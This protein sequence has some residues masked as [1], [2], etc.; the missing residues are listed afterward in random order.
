MIADNFLKNPVSR[1][2]LIPLAARAQE[3]LS[4]KALFIDK[5]AEEIF[6]KLPKDAIDFKLNPVMRTATAIRVRYLDD[7]A[8][9][10]IADHKNPI[11]VQLGAGFDT[12][13]SRT[14]NGQSIQINID[15]PEVMQ[16][17]QDFI[18]TKNDREY[19]WAYNITDTAWIERLKKEFRDFDIMFI[20]EG[21]LM[22]LPDND[23]ETL[24]K[25]LAD[26]FIDS[27]IAFDTASL[28]SKKMIN[29]SIVGKMGAC[30]QWSYNYDNSIEQWHP[31]L[32][33]V[34]EKFYFD[35]YRQ[36]LGFFNILRYLP[37]INHSSAIYLYNIHSKSNI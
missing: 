32:K 5:Q 35:L 22:Y 1:T 12:R 31:F 19:N 29:K 24:F 25:S 18:P 7:L 20:A 6:K 16:S 21:L 8:K 9:K 15:L 30:F 37:I 11:I 33:K 13:F 36:R 27:Y 28:A 14:D 2:L 26:N 3:S 10:F 4:K 34:S 23:V 17:R